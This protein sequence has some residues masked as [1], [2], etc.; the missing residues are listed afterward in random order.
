VTATAAGT[1][2][3]ATTRTALAAFGLSLLAGVLVD[4]AGDAAFTSLSASD[5]LGLILGE[6][7]VSEEAFLATVATF[8]VAMNCVSHQSTSALS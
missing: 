6:A 5:G 3:F 2:A 1:A 7:G 4:D 8:E